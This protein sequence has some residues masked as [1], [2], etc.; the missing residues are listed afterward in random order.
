MQKPAGDSSE[1]SKIY[2]IAIDSGML[3][4]NEIRT[5]EGLSGVGPDG[6]VAYVPANKLESPRPVCNGTLFNDGKPLTAEQRAAMRAEWQKISHAAGEVVILPATVDPSDAVL[7]ERE[8]CAKIAERL[9]KVIEAYPPP[10]SGRTDLLNE[11]CKIA[12]R[13]IAESIRER[14]TPAWAERQTLM[15]QYRSVLSDES[16][17]GDLLVPDSLR[18]EPERHILYSKDGNVIGTQANN[19]G[20]RTSGAYG[21]W[22]RESNPA[23]TQELRA[24]FLGTLV[25][26]KGKGYVMHVD[27]IA[28]CRV[29]C[30]TDKGLMDFAPDEL[31]VLNRVNEPSPASPIV[32]GNCPIVIGVDLDDDMPEPEIMEKPS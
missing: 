26:H 23:K 17:G 29:V 1:R 27:D 3:T 13:K 24:K 22:P 4:I 11:G 5:L 2:R 19:S 6:D 32:A 8:A 16:A 31:D 9:I 10:S 12:A 18:D 7:A 15:A 20:S 21:K 14:W 28:D 30:R 25:K